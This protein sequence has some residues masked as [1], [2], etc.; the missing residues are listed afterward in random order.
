MTQRQD[1]ETSTTPSEGVERSPSLEAF[2]DQEQSIDIIRATVDITKEAVH[3]IS[4]TALEAVREGALFM[5]VI[6]ARG[7]LVDPFGHIDAAIWTEPEV[8]QHMIDTAYDFCEELT[9]REAGNFY[10]S[11]KYLPEEKRRAI[12]AYYAFCRRAD[13]IADGDYV[14]VFP[15]GSED[16]PE[17]ITYRSSIERLSRGSPVLDRSA[18]NEK[19]S[20]LFYYRKKLSTAYGNMTST[21]PIFI[22]LKDTVKRHGIHRELLDDMI[23]GMENDFHQNRYQ[24]FEELYSYCYRVASTVGLV[25]IEIY[26]YDDP[27]AREY[28]ES[29]GVFMQLINIIRDVA[30]DAERDRIY[31]PLEDLARWGISEEDVKSGKK[32]L[33]HPGWEPFVK[34]YLDRADGYRQRAFQL[35][36]HLDRSARYSPAAM[37]SFYQSIMKKIVK[38]NGDVFTER[39][40][41]SKTEKM[42]LAAYVYVRFR[43]IGL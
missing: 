1:S 31:L 42:I 38:R 5:G 16:D 15:G 12:M 37:A 24:T 2:R 30:E 10:H 19:M 27:R 21:D 32:L 7:E 18:Y 40:Q 14:D 4:I 35:L 41:L 26:G 11:F 6:G 28:A 22:A 9:R 39:V 43:F 25:C 33:K 23:S 20:Q 36:S 29:W 13:D 8:P 3:A 17:S 34:E